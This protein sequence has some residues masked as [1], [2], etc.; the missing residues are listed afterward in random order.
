[1]TE[2][3]RVAGVARRYFAKDATTMARQFSM[4][5]Q[6]PPIDLLA[7]AADAGGRTSPYRSLKN[8]L[9][10]YIVVK[11]TQGNAATV[12]LSVL[13]ASAVAGTGSKAV[14]AVPIWSNLDTSVNDTLTARTAA[15]SYTTDAGVKNK[16]VIFE[17]TPEACMDVA[18]GFD[19]LAVSTGA[20]N[21]ANI[22]EATLFILGSYQSASPPNSYVD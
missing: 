12:L 3:R 13:Q 19:C 5:A 1:M 10:A 18:N 17:I 16:I 4:Q 6:F 7:P 2:T 8:A 11:M 21:A 22:T 14:T 20:S 9:K 15:V